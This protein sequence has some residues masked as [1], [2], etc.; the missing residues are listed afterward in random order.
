[1]KRRIRVGLVHRFRILADVLGRA[2]RGHPEISWAG[3]LTDAREIEAPENLR[4]FDVLL[5]EA[6]LFE[7]LPRKAIRD[8]RKTRPEL[9]IVPMGLVSNDQ[10]VAH[11]EAGA[12]GYVAADASFDQLVETICGVYHDQPPCSSQVAASVSA[13]MVQ[14]SCTAPCQE[15]ISLPEDVRLTPK[16]EEVLE[17]AAGGL[18]NKQI[19]A[20]LGIAVSTVKIHIHK[21][22]GKLQVGKRREAIQLAYEAGLLQDPPTSV[23]LALPRN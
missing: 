21:I 6:P 4:S 23:P 16:E 20:A 18:S 1:M 11:I 12:S 14:L 5:I 17:L 13:R 8:F 19:A 3:V 7:S 22:L 15:P 9:K 10:I 2:F